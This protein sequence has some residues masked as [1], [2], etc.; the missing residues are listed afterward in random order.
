MSL[1]NHLDLIIRRTFAKSTSLSAPCSHMFYRG[2]VKTFSSHSH[3]STTPVVI[4]TPGCKDEGEHIP[5]RAN[6]F[7]TT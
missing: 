6:L 5:L 7:S 4:M 1:Q 2:W 3:I